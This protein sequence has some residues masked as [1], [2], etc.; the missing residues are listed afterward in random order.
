MHYDYD[1]LVGQEIRKARLQ[2]GWSQQQLTAKM[3]AAGCPFLDQQ[4]ISKI[5]QGARHIFVLQIKLF[6]QVLGMP[7]DELF[8][9]IPTDVLEMEY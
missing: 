7:L 6:Q 4:C 3:Q 2:K 9:E 1:R 5:E 8:P